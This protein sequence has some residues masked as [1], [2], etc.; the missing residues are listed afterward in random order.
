MGTG[1]AQTR[2]EAIVDFAGILADLRNSA[3]NPA[4]RTMSG[5]SKAIS[6]TTLHEAVR[7][8]RL[9]SWATTAEFVKACGAD[10]QDYRERWEAA[11]RAVGQTIIAPGP[12]ETVV[13]PGADDPAEPASSVPPPARTPHRRR[14][15]LA[16]A[17]VVPAAAA[18]VIG[19]ITWSRMQQHSPT[20]TSSS[21]GYQPADC[22]V[23]QTDPPS[24]PPQNR[25]DRVVFL[26]D[27]TL[28]DCTDVPRGQTVRKIWRLRNAGSVTW[29][30]YSLHRMDAQSR[31]DCQSITDVPVPDA[32]P[33]ETVDV[34]VD[35]T[36]PAVSR[37]CYVRFKMLDDAGKMAYPGG[38][39]LNFQLIVD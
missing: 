30:G 2:T 23:H 25:G 4:F 17:L 24:A 13:G 18:G 39:P 36:T 12:D 8:N 7:G 10:P 28:A 20:T 1:A 19:G 15:V 11:Y 34:A 33:G 32:A 31:T 6:H 27:V 5:R 21:P 38:R 26:R 3:G 35:V 37:F 16:A 9:P 22:P 29:S 14:R